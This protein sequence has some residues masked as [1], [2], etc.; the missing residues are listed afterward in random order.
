MIDDT[1]FVIPARGGSKGLPHKN[2]LPVG[3]RPLIAYTLDAVRSIT[4]D[5]N[6]C[7][8]TDDTAIQAVVEAEGLKLPFLRPAELATDT[9][10]SQAV[11]LHAFHYYTHVLHRHYT[12][13]CL[14]QPTSPLRTATHIKGVISLWEDT[15]DM[16]VSVRESADNPYF[17]LFEEDT[18]GYLIHSKESH[19]IRRQDAPPVWAYNGAIYLFN[20]GS[21]QEKPISAFTRIKKYVMDL[22][23]SQDVDTWLDLECVKAILVRKDQE[24]SNK[25]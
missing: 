23:S 21:L 9:A 17:N 8:S 16:V 22:E 20:P 10:G 4:A 14:L 15:L 1:L 18:T 2:I 19:Y 11:L 6:I 25:L 7:V 24:N 13:I 12:R 3:G 5:T